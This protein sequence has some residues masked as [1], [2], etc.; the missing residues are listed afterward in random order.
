MRNRFRIKYNI[1]PSSLNC[2]RNGNANLYRFYSQLARGTF[3]NVQ[4]T[5]NKTITK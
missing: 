3:Q 5:D 1:Q 2:K 4:T